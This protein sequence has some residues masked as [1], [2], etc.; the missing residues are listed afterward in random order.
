[1]L[2]PPRPQDNGC[3]ERAHATTRCEFWNF[4][5]GELKVPD[6]NQAL[7]EHLHCYHH[8]RPHRSLGLL[9]SHAFLA[10]LSSAT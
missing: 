7:Q 9:T 8:R 6:I 2:P 1:M 3:L 10:N 4:H 5:Y